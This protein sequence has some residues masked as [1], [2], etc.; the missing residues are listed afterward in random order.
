MVHLWMFLLS[1]AVCVI[2]KSVSIRLMY[3]SVKYHHKQTESVQFLLLY[4]IITGSSFTLLSSL[5]NCIKNSFFNLIFFKLILNLTCPSSCTGR[6]STGTEKSDRWGEEAAGRPGSGS[7]CLCRRSLCEWNAVKIHK[8][9]AVSPATCRFHVPP[10][11]SVLLPGSFSRIKAL[12]QSRWRRTMLTDLR[13]TWSEFSSDCVSAALIALHV[14]AQPQHGAAF[15]CPA[16]APNSEFSRHATKTF[17][18]GVVRSVISSVAFYREVSDETH[19][20]MCSQTLMWPQVAE[21]KTQSSSTS[22]CRKILY[23]KCQYHFKLFTQV[24]V[25]YTLKSS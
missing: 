2:N 17:A 22:T 21:N 13:Q 12:I 15:R 3:L 11:R 19:Y 1:C 9:S 20:L 16:A 5:S 10:V 8:R 18:W 4:F 7:A 14:T 25:L 23:Y 24:E 6:W